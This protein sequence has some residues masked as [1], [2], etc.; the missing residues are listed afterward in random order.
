MVRTNAAGVMEWSQTYDWLAPASD[1][2]LRGN[3]AL[4]VAMDAQL[5]AFAILVD[6]A[7]GAISGQHDLQMTM[8]LYAYTDQQGNLLELDCF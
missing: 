2:I 7:S 3:S 6:P 5:N 8:P 4:F 1:L